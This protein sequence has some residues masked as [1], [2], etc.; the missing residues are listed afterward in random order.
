MSDDSRVQR[1]VGW[2]ETEGRLALRRDATGL[3]AP[4]I[5]VMVVGLVMIGMAQRHF[6]PVE[7]RVATKGGFTA[8]PARG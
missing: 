1:P 2:P 5:I 3:T 8:R 7:W 4:S 6:R